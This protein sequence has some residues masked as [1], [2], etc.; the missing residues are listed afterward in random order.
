ML[1]VIFL[2]TFKTLL[3]FAAQIIPTFFIR[4]FDCGTRPTSEASICSDTYIY[5]IVEQLYTFDMA[6]STLNMKHVYADMK[7][8]S[9][10]WVIMFELLKV[11][12]RRCGAA[13]RSDVR[14]AQFAGRSLRSDPTPLSRSSA[15]APKGSITHIMFYPCL[16][17]NANN[18]KSTGK[19]TPLFLS[20]GV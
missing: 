10:L 3:L 19:K 7:I 12:I 2:R 1:S 16:K 4:L 5:H 18:L 20:F 17:Y 6:S 15:A 8:D 11:A 13:R 14:C 9:P